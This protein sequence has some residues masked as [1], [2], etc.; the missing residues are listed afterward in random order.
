MKGNLP[1]HKS[2]TVCNPS[3]TSLQCRRNLGRVEFNVIRELGGQIHRLI[4]VP[5]PLKE[6]D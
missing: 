4:C 6:G 5:D 3:I 1:C 2:V